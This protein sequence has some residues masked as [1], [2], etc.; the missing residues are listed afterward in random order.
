MIFFNRSKNNQNKLE[1]KQKDKNKVESLGQFFIHWTDVKRRPWSD[2]IIIMNREDMNNNKINELDYVLLKHTIGESNKKTLE[3]AALVISQDNEFV[4]MK[5]LEKGNLGVDQTYREALFIHEHEKLEVLKIERKYDSGEK[6]LGKMNFQKVVLR[7][8]Y[9][10]SY[11]EQ[12]IPIACI[13]D[14][15][16]KGMGI[17]YGDRIIIE[18]TFRKIIAKCAKPDPNMET[19][20]QKLME[21]P[22]TATHKRIS[23]G[24]SCCDQ[25]ETPNAERKTLNSIR[26]SHFRFPEEYGVVSGD[27]TVHDVIHPIFIDSMAA[28]QLGVEP[29]DPVKIRRAFSSELMK[30]IT[31][32]GTACI[33]GLTILFP[34]LFTQ[35]DTN[36]H[37]FIIAVLLLA[38]IIAVTTIFGPKYR[39]DL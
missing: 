16:L 31:D 17:K 15:I 35:T 21:Y 10:S 32:V 24:K 27:E 18:S 3:I 38:G 13:S 8:Q 25:I 7:V 2:F 30:R 9:N 28:Q 5:Q 1:C 6:F 34:I 12:Q 29:F 36:Q 37:P 22:Y 20:H 33:T 39:T 4:C 14:E 23:C 11:M 26:F 19:L